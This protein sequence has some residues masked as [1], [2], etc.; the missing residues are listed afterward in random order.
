MLRSLQLRVNGRTQRL[1]RLVDGEQATDLDVVG[2]LHK[3]SERQ[4]RI[5]RAT[6]DLATGRNK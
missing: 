3:L 4:A 1:G 2:Q 5:Q 6:Y